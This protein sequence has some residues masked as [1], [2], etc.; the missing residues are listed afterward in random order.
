VG[1]RRRR[2][3]GA[4]LG[5]VGAL[6]LIAGC[7]API[8]A[9]PGGAAIALVPAGSIPARLILVAALTSVALVLLGRYRAL[10]GTGAFAALMVLVE[11][12]SYR[13]RLVTVPS[14]GPPADAIVASFA[15]EWGWALLACGP[16]L[17]LLAGLFPGH[18]R[19]S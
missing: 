16:A 9:A 2:P 7:F 5:L 10:L 17:L 1:R 8:A 11:F 4:A 3:S 19:R 14:A 13:D 12:F 15:Y 6:L 18:R